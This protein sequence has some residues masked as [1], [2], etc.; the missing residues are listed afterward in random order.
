MLDLCDDRFTL[1]WTSHADDNDS[2]SV[3]DGFG[4]EVMVYL[5]SADSETVDVSR[6]AHM[7]AV[8]IVCVLLDVDEAS[9]ARLILAAQVLSGGGDDAL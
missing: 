7:Q 9:A 6:T 3:S 2:L 1:R 8:D 4:A 5:P